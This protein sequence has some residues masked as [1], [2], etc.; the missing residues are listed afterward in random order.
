MLYSAF[1]PKIGPDSGRIALRGT[2]SSSRGTCWVRPSGFRDANLLFTFLYM[3]G[4]VSAAIG[5]YSI[6]KLCTYTRVNVFTKLFTSQLTRSCYTRL[7]GALA[8]TI[9]HET[10]IELV[11]DFLEDLPWNS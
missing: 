10:W 6:Q 3:L 5:I 11:Y 8:L 7:L 1:V 2:A 9:I 4:P